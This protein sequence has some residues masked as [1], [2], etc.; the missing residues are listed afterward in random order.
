M[1]LML[2][3]NKYYTLNPRYIA[4][5]ITV[6]VNT[7]IQVFPN[8]F[9]MIIQTFRETLRQFI[10]SLLSYKAEK[11][12]WGMR[13]NGCSHHSFILQ[14]F[15]SKMLADKQKFKFFRDF[16]FWQQKGLDIDE[17]PS[18]II[19][20]GDKFKFENT[21]QIRRVIMIFS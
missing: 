8:T 21:F 19:N 18:L 10:S 6:N 7:R 5:Y 1:F 20:F 4:S 14:R 3:Y 17:S 16:I 13:I 11:N 12:H 9:A 2:Y 15:S